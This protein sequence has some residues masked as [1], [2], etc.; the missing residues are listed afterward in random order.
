MKRLLTAIVLLLLPVFTATAQQGCIRF[1]ELKSMQLSSMGSTEAEVVFVSNRNDLVIGALSID[2]ADVQPQP[3]NGMYE[4]RVHLSLKSSNGDWHR[5]RTFNVG[6]KN[7]SI[8]ERFKKKSIEGG[9]SI[10]VEAIVV[11]HPIAM[12]ERTQPNALHIN[13]AEACVVFQSLLLLDIK[14]SYANMATVTTTTSQGGLNEYQVVLKLSQLR[15]GA[16]LLVSA[17][18]GSSNVLEL[19]VSGLQKREKRTYEIMVQSLGENIRPVSLKQQY[20]AIR[21]EPKSSIVTFDGELLPLTDGTTSKLVPFGTYNYRVECANYYAQSGQVTVNDPDNTVWLN[22]S[23]KP[24]FGWIDVMGPSAEGGSVYIDNQLVGTAPLGSQ[25]IK[26]GKHNVKVLKPHFNA[27]DQIVEVRDGQRTLV[28]PTLTSNFVQVK[29]LVGKNAEIWINGELYG[30]GV[31]EDTFSVGMYTVETYLDGCRP[32]SRMLSITQEMKDTIIT[33][34]TPQLITGALRVTSTPIGAEI[35]IDGKPYGSTPVRISKLEVGEHAVSLSLKGYENYNTS[36]VVVE[37]EEALVNSVLSAATPKESNSLKSEGTKSQ[38]QEP[39][40]QAKANKGKGES[41]KKELTGEQQRKAQKNETGSQPKEAV[42]HNVTI[43]CNVPDAIMY[44]D[45]RF[46]G[47][48]S[49]LYSIAEGEHMLE[50]IASNYVTYS[51]KINVKSAKTYTIKLVEDT[52]TY[53]V[54]LRCNVDDVKVYVDSRLLNVGADKVLPLPYGIHTIEVSADHHNPYNAT[55]NVVS[56]TTLT[57]ELQKGAFV[58]K[59]LIITIGDVQFKMVYVKGGTYLMGGMLSTDE[60]PLHSVELS[61]FYIGQTEVTQAL[62]RVVM[63]D[64]PTKVAWS[65]AVG[66]GDD[67]PAYRVTYNDAMLFVKRLNQLTGRKFRLPTEAEW[68]YAASGG[69]MSKEYIYSGSNKLDEV[70]WASGKLSPVMKKY[71]NELGIYDMSG[72]VWEW[73]SDWYGGNY[74][75]VSPMKNPQG[76]SMGTQRVRRGGC[77]DNGENACR[78]AHRDYLHPSNPSNF[79]GF[80]LVMEDGKN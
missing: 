27:F 21:V 59:N 23:L 12:I 35:L 49:G 10:R 41:E 42:T 63:A 54:A 64:S 29:F 76:P 11:E 15:E 16:R 1:K 14:A 36:V 30:R 66:I 31:V 8:I 61:S 80:R 72:N 28:T 38:V 34:A 75:N 79:V 45:R 44:L 46:L 5:D 37:G 40:A 74:Y 77:W 43:K 68:E 71:S 39:A 25:E 19:D 73:C 60:Q 6:I 55:I 7:T 3:S 26:S 58:D 9:R 24:N 51:G 47:K 13:A 32:Q 57:V 52:R 62:W 33:L 4:Y 56:D 65:E 69:L 2:K 17:K 20:V 50:V 18:D 78:I 22:I 67:Y 48:G 53:N 70:G